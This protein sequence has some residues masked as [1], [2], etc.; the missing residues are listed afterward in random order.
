MEKDF[1]KNLVLRT[2]NL[3]REFVQLTSDPYGPGI[4]S[5]VKEELDKLVLPLLEFITPTTKGT[6]TVHYESIVSDLNKVLDISEIIVSNYDTKYLQEISKK[7]NVSFESLEKPQLLFKDKVDNSEM[8]FIPRLK[9]KDNKIVELD[10]YFV[11]YQKTKEVPADFKFSNPYHYE[12]EQSKM[13]YGFLLKVFSNPVT[14]VSLDSRKIQFIESYDDLVKLANRLLTTT[15]FS[16]DVHNH[17]FRSFLG[18]TC[19]IEISF[20][21]QDYLIDALK[22]REHLHILNRAFTSSQILKIGMNC[23]EK[24][25]WLQRDFGI[26]NVNFLDLSLIVR[27]L[28]LPDS[29]PFLANKFL[30]FSFKNIY[31]EFDF[32]KRPINQ[33]EKIYL[34]S[35]S[36]LI[37][38]LFFAVKDLIPKFGFDKF[39]EQIFEESKMFCFYTYEKPFPLEAYSH[40]FSD[41]RF[42]LNKT[43]ANK[44]IKLMMWRDYTARLA[45]ESNEYIF[46]NELFETLLFYPHKDVEELKT[47]VKMFSQK[48]PSN[49]LE[50][51]YSILEDNDSFQENKET[52]K[53]ELNENSTEILQS[54]FTP[55]RNMFRNMNG[56]ILEKESPAY[57]QTELHKMI[58]W[59]SGKKDISEQFDT[60]RKLFDDSILKGALTLPNI[61]D[62]PSENLN[63]DLQ[64]LKNIINNRND[65]GYV[66]REVQKIPFLKGTCNELN[67]IKEE[68]A[69]IDFLE[70]SA[71]KE[72]LPQNIGEIYD[73]GNNIRKRNKNKKKKDLKQTKFTPDLPS[74]SEGGSQSSFHQAAEFPLRMSQGKGSKVIKEE[75]STSDNILKDLG[76]V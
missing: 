53:I 76:W 38:R 31:V 55:T 52:S 40:I 59:S 68:E 4:S 62:S 45:D 43:H 29:L 37:L 60:P 67:E 22:L 41:A 24:L 39:F 74:F 64:H 58:H 57:D 28:N 56:N 71:L 73:L 18:F 19:F 54:L 32:R 26:F 9:I 7:S 65:S 63:E 12:V 50:T 72:N 3:Q 48:I 16:F 69:A 25:L 1:E 46:P 30:G 5:K 44:L 35:F 49:Y 6:E 13:N 23:Q 21:T 17:S 10:P 14:A 47:T 36:H 20:D 8:P 34:Q 75:N 66:K 11:E 51:I 61:L 70:F 33:A 2:L 15:H 27:Q 42:N